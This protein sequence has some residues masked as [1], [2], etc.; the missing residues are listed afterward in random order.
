MKSAKT[1][2]SIRML[3]FFQATTDVISYIVTFSIL[4][5]D[6]FS[7]FK[8]KC[9]GL[10]FLLHHSLK[11][12]PYFFVILSGGEA[13]QMIFRCLFI[14]LLLMPIYHTTI[15]LRNNFLL[16]WEFKVYPLFLFFLVYFLHLK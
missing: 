15:G 7:S 10:L 12:R 1:V 3:P 9:F 13:T 4:T 5:S 8:L 11:K 2:I 16:Y 14:I 6:F